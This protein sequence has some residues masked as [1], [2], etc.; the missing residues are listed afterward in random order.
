MPGSLQ[1]Y[2]P[3]WLHGGPLAKYR[4]RRNC[5]APDDIFQYV[6]RGLVNRPDPGWI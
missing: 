6:Q 4:G 3:S 5:A 1:P 2:P